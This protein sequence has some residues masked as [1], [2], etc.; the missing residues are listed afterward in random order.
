MKIDQLY[1]YMDSI[2]EVRKASKGQRQVIVLGKVTAGFFIH[3]I[4]SIL[5]AWSIFT[6]CTAALVLA[7]PSPNVD[8][9]ATWQDNTSTLEIPQPQTPTIQLTY[10]LYSSKHCCLAYHPGFHRKVTKVPPRPPSHLMF[11]IPPP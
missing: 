8:L 7:G 5:Q 1:G 3:G 4:Y 10:K 11:L 6:L 9:K 2:G